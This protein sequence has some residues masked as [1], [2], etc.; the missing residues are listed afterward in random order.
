MATVCKMHVKKVTASQLRGSMSNHLK[1]AR[2]NYVLLVQNRRQPEK[3]VV[4]KGWLDNLVKE[5]ESIIAT[6]EILADRK[7][8][9]RLVA[10][11]ETIDSDVE[12][13]RLYS[14]DEVF[15]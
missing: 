2:N 11:A 6:I 7:L 10:L 12:N 9:N 4:D 1:E 15:G 3:Y 5:R 14:M 13:N 8:T